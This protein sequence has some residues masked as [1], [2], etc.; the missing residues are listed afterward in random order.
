MLLWLG[1][2]RLLVFRV[3]F[4]AVESIMRAGSAQ[5][6]A[7][8]AALLADLAV[9]L[10]NFNLDTGRPTRS[11]ECPRWPTAPMRPR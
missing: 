1:V 5:S 4:P 11:A 10:P 6:L 7:R 8:Y 3:L 2:A 9:P